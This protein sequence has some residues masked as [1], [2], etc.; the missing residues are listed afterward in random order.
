MTA[1]ILH[2]NADCGPFARLAGQLQA[3]ILKVVKSVAKRPTDRALQGA[4]QLSG[5]QVTNDTVAPAAG[6]LPR[7]LSLCTDCALS[8]QLLVGRHAPHQICFHLHIDVVNVLTISQQLQ[9]ARTA[10]GTAASMP[11]RKRPKRPH[12]FET[13][14]DALA[15]AASPSAG[16]MLNCKTQSSQATAPRYALVMSCQQQVST[17]MA[18]RMLRRNSWA[19]CC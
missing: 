12:C 16:M 15:T 9:R 11:D 6:I 17:C 18:S 19:S 1:G 3:D 13:R 10:A 5:A 2:L 7:L 8:F 4:L 14:R